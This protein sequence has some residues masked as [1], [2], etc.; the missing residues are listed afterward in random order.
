MRHI[1]LIA[2]GVCGASIECTEV[3]TLTSQDLLS[4]FLVC[5]KS[6][7]EVFLL[8]L[9]V[10]ERLINVILFSLCRKYDGVQALDLSECSSKSIHFEMHLRGHAH[11]S[12]FQ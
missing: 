7:C 9:D 5:V 10:V 2:L 12:H 4:R 3:A 6:S 8:L 1:L 11:Y